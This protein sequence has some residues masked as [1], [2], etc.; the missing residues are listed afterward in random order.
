[1]HAEMEKERIICAI[2][3]NEEDWYDSTQSKNSKEL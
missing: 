1:M 2:D 3:I